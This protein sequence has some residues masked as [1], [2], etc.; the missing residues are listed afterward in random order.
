MNQFWAGDLQSL[1]VS[2]GR[3]SSLLLPL[4]GTFIC[5]EIGTARPI[6]FQT[7]LA[8]FVCLFHPSSGNQLASPPP[9]VILS[10]LFFCLLFLLFT[11]DANRR[12][13]RLP[14][15]PPIIMALSLLT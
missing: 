7:S 9:H 6:R 5:G 15:P 1:E 8:R 2:V 12:G 13:S 11:R 4:L 10:V 3:L 14:P